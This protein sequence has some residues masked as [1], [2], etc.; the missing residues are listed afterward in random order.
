MGGGL[1]NL[2]SEGNKN[3]ILN[4]NPSKT[5]FKT[6]YAKY[7][8]FGMDKQRIDVNGSRKLSMINDSQF[9]FQI[10]READLLMD[11]YFVVQLPNIWS[12]IR[13][14]LPGVSNEIMLDGKSYTNNIDRNFW[15]YEFKWIENL[16]AQMIRRIRY[17]IGS[18][19]IQEFTGHYLYNLS[20][21]HI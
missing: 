7:T 11:T 14:I 20:L 19:V 15:P 17:I 10:P 2:V 8:N 13:E 4:G 3:V 9:L 1:L 6:T 16:G 12:P 18:E 5:F 21:I